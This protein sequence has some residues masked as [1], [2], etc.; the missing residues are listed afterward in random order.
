MCS[1]CP[2]PP[3]PPGPAIVETNS[4]PPSR[5]SG[6]RCGAPAEPAGAGAAEGAGAVTPRPGEEAGRGR[7]AARAGGVGDV[8][9]VALDHLQAAEDA[10]LAAVRPPARVPVP[11]RVRG[12]A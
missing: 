4:V 2:V 1:P 6:G 8:E 11:L 10:G 5:R 12:S 7:A 3:P 9:A